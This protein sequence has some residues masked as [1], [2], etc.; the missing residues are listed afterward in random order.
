MKK[1]EKGTETKSPSEGEE[2]TFV[3]PAWYLQQLRLQ[4]IVLDHEILSRTGA[5]H[6]GTK[7]TVTE[8]HGTLRSRSRHSILEKLS[9]VIVKIRIIENN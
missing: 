3:L 6:Q 9:A 8:F 2:H 1:T 4:Q 5:T 7:I